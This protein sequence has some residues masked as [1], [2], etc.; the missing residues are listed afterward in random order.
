MGHTKGRKGYKKD[1]W[2]WKRHGIKPSKGG[3]KVESGFRELC[4]LLTKL[5]VL[6]WLLLLSLWQQYKLKH[7]S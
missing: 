4:L 6:T 2:Q 5:L 3:R 1:S 7:L